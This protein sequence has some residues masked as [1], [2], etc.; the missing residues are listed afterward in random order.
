MR[1]SEKNTWRDTSH[2]VEDRS[3]QHPNVHNYRQE[4][5]RFQPTAFTQV[6]TEV[7]RRVKQGGN[8]HQPKNG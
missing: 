1:Y 2:P 7:Q 8:T 6:E 3:P 4:G 5:I